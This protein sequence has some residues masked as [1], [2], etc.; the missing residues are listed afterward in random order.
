MINSLQWGFSDFLYTNG[1]NPIEEWHSGL[2]EDARFIFDKILKDCRK[3]ELHTDWVA[4][5]RYLKGKCEKH[6]IWELE[7]RSDKRQHRV[8]CVFDPDVGKR[9]VLLIGC[10]HKQSV[11]T[12]K[13]A[14]TEACN[15]AAIFKRE[16]NSRERKVAIDR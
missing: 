1:D 2:S 14:L 13:N 3:T 15:R 6:R 4:F 5:K 9:V 11:Y 12:P 7:F 10:Y 16:R 8:L